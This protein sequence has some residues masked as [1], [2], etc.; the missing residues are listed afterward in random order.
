MRGGNDRPH[1]PGQR[2]REIA[3]KLCSP[4]TI[5]HLVDPIVADLQ[6]EWNAAGQR[7]RLT[8]AWVRLRGY[9]A[10]TQ[11]IALY[12]VESA[13]S[14]LVRNAFGTTAEER[15]FH[16]RAGVG[17]L[18]TLAMSTALVTVY[19]MTISTRSLVFLFTHQRWPGP[20]TVAEVLP[21]AIAIAMNPRGLLLLAPCF[22]VGTLP[23]SLMFG[24]FLGVRLGVTTPPPLLRPFL[25]GAAGISLVATLFTFVFTGWI[26]PELGQR[27]REFFMASISNTPLKPGTPARDLRE[28]RLSELGA[29]ARAEDALGRREASQRYHVEW[30]RRMAW[31][32]A[33]LGFGLVGL[34]LAAQRR[35]WTTRQVGA[36]TLAT[37]VFYY[38]GALHVSARA[39]DVAPRSPFLVA[40]SAD[41]LL[42]L[43]A[44]ALIFRAHRHRRSS[45][46]AP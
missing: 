22:L 13:I 46:M 20:P 5:E 33:S 10:F 14:H 17:T 36:M 41:I 38:W 29:R 34:G 25:R 3:S 15:A 39:L 27:Y 16:R 24:I 43:L 21:H 18:A 31:A 4:A 37:T 2:L 42:A 1:L 35:T 44:A 12:A 32:A 28:L 19:G 26:V 6:H 11:A 30:H 23:P 40:W 7:S 9:A 8:R 45:L